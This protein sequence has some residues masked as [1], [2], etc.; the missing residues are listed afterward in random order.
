MCAINGNAFTNSK[1][2]IGVIYVVR[3]PRDIVVSASKYFNT[4]YEKT[5]KI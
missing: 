5:K 3:D 2:T 1:N 4:N